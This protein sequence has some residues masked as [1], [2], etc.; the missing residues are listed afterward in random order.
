M[1]VLSVAE[2]DTSQ[3]VVTAI[4]DVLIIACVLLAVLTVPIQMQ[5]GRALPRHSVHP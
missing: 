4:D 3:L 1:C 2:G 5:P